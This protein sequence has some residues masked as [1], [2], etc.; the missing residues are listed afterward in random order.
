MK[1]IMYVI[2]F[3]GIVV[4][5]CNHP[6]P[7]TDQSVF[8]PIRYSFRSASFRQNSES[9]LPSGF[10]GRDKRTG[11]RNSGHPEKSGSSH[12]CQYHR[13]HGKIGAVVKQGILCVFQSPGSQYER[14]D[15]C[16]CRG[17]YARNHGSYGRYKSE[18]R[19]I[20]PDQNGIR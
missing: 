15:Q 11:S 8:N 13:G 18:R 5:S 9:S 7:V 17:D 1:K 12:F 16:H 19:A 14:F 4:Q 6:Q 20:C 10:P 3:A 2:C